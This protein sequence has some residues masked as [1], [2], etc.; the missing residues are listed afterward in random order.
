MCLRY[1]GE[2]ITFHS[3]HTSFCSRQWLVN[4]DGGREKVAVMQKEVW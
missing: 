1:Q 2:H 3:R 4:T